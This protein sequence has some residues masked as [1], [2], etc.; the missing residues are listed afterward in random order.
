VLTLQLHLQ[1]SQGEQ[2]DPKRTRL[3][4][5]PPN[6]RLKQG[7]LPSPVTHKE[8]TSDASEAHKEGTQSP[9]PNQP[10]HPSQ[11]ARG[12]G[13]LSSPPSDTQPFSQFVYPPESRTYAVDDE[14]AEEVWGYLV[15]MDS[16]A[17]DVMV[18]RRRQACPVPTTRVGKTNGIDKVDK[19][20]F[21]AQE[22]QYEN[23]KQEHGLPAGG[24]LVGR[25]RE[26]GKSWQRMHSTL[27]RAAFLTMP[28]TAS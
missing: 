22:E 9:K 21:K 12:P 28:Q 6:G 3:S 10:A 13:G 14:E 4:P 15:P 1:Y 11:A 20:E 23:E 2:V 16:R 25:H 17:G 5:P 19:E 26:C 8:S 7:P 24:Y 27:H 18:L